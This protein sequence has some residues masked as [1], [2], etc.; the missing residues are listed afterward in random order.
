MLSNKMLDALDK[1]INYEIFSA[2]LYVSM[3]NYFQE[4]NLEGFANFF[5]V[6]IQE[7]LAHARIFYEYIYRMG[8]QVVLYPINKPE[9]SFDSSLDLFEKALKHE[10]SVTERIYKLVDIAID[11]KDHA[12]NSFLQWFVNEQVE[13]EENFKRLVDKLGF[14]GDK[15]QPMFMLNAELAQRVFV[16][17]SPLAQGQQ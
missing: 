14:I 1:Q 3:E 9:V 17:P 15:V 6:Q 16:L 11:D 10:K 8:G 2:Y 7:E 4:K 13:E 12:T 5:K